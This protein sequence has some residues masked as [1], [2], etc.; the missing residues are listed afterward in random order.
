MYDFCLNLPIFQF[1]LTIDNLNIYRHR[2]SLLTVLVATQ[3]CLI[4][5]TAWL[6]TLPTVARSF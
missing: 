3:C 6:L 1:R 5:V 2:A 4:S